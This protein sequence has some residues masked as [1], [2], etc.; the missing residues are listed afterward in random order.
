MIGVT[1][2]DETLGQVDVITQPTCQSPIAE[3]Q[4]TAI[5][6]YHFT[7]W[8]DGNTDNPRTI[9]LTQDTTFAAHFA[10][11]QYTLT[12]NAG[13]HGTAT[14]SGIY[15]FGDTITIQAFPEEH[16]HFLRW[17]DN[18]TEN[19]R[20]YRIEDNIVLTAFFVVDT[21]TVSVAS[22]DISRGMV[23]ATGTEFAYGTPCTVTATAYSGY[24]FA[25][26]S[27]GATYNPYTFAVLNDVELSA[28]FESIDGIDD[29]EADDIRIYSAEGRIVVEGTTD[30]VRVYDVV[31]HQV[32]CEQLPVG[33]YMVK[34]G[35]LPACKV[36]VIR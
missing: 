18:N 35:K 34:V 21:Y 32:R 30:E 10:P 20:Q 4:A 16:Y 36:V 22:S 14:G 3:I 7:Q 15:N 23:E 19:P 17:N 27:N 11:N 6:G 1:S 9:T 26:W 33:V 12:V 25:R 2:A 31:G 29:I 13:E 28:I 8:D 24:T 5:Y